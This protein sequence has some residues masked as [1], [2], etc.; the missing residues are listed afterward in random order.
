MVHAINARG[1]L[2]AVYSLPVSPQVYCAATHRGGGTERDPKYRI[3]NDGE[4]C[5]DSQPKAQAH[6][7]SVMSIHIYDYT[8]H[9]K[10][11][12]VHAARG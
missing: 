9:I 11:I 1:A 4:Q 10:C 5:H 6:T 8:A 12:C 3:V 2:Q 7:T